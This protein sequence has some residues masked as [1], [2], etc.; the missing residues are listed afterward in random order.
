MSAVGL[1]VAE[2]KTAVGPHLEADIGETT[3][4]I[5]DYPEIAEHLAAKLDEHLAY[6]GIELKAE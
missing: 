1:Q 3:N 6:I 2:N 4:R 5:D